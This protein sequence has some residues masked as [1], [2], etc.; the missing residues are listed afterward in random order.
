M[1]FWTWQD[2]LATGMS[3]RR[4]HILSYVT[5]SKYGSLRVVLKSVGQLL[6]VQNKKR[7]YGLSLSIFSPYTWKIAIFDGCGTENSKFFY[8]FR[9]SCA[10]PWSC[11]KYILHRKCFRVTRKSILEYIT[12][13][14]QCSKTFRKNEKIEFFGYFFYHFGPVKQ[15]T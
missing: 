15:F 6:T 11:M 7:C 12:C 8:V 10:V 5:Q 9:L 4:S 14:K 3:F 1:S 13:V 2:Y